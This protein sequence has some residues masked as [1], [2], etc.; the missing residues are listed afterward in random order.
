VKLNISTCLLDY[1][2]GFVL[3]PA[4]VDKGDAGGILSEMRRSVEKVGVLWHESLVKLV[5]MG[6][7][8]VSVMLGKNN[9]VAAKLRSLQPAMVAV[10]CYDHKLELAFKDA[11]KHVPLDTKVTTCL[12]QGLYYLYHNNALNR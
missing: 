2:S 12:L 7:D 5:G 3:N 10:H 9:G 8:G 4:F 6:S 1:F 11:I